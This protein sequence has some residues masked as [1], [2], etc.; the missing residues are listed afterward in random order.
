MEAQH[1]KYYKRGLGGTNAQG[2]SCIV[3]LEAAHMCE[4]SAIQNRDCLR[5]TTG[6][7][8]EGE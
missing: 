5:S 1:E 3:T 4:V 6:K 2:V 7:Q 8:P